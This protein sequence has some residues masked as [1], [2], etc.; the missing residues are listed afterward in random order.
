MLMFSVISFIA[1]SELLTVMTLEKLCFLAWIIASRMARTLAVRISVL[2]ID[3]AIF[4]I[5]VVVAFL[6]MKLIVVLCVFL[7]FVTSILY[8]TQS[9]SGDVH[10]CHR[11]L[12][13]VEEVFEL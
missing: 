4:A 7:F 3:V 13:L 9:G 8:L 2:P 12:V 10:C 1:V 6:Q 5:V 11:D